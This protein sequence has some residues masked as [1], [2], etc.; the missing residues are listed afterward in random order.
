M[1]AQDTV[2]IGYPAT[3]L[4]ELV[5]DLAT[6]LVDTPPAEAEGGA[7]G[8]P[9]WKKALKEAH[10]AGKSVTMQLAVEAWIPGGKIKVQ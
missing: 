4:A 3:K 6:S 9:A 10:A 5:M 7:L 2:G 1:C 8:V